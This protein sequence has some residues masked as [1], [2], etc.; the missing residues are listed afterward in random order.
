MDALIRLEG[1]GEPSELAMFLDGERALKGTVRMI[2]AAPSDGQLGAGVD[3]LVVALGS[4]GVGV[5][6]THAL[7]AW[8]RNQRADV[9]ITVTADDRTVELEAR[10]VSD[11]PALIKEILPVDDDR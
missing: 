10:R 1:P 8:L 3:F 2:T 7:T 4:G 11:V 5:A 9:R 6:L